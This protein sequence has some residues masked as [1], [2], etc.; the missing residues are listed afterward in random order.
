MSLAEW[1][2]PDGGLDLPGDLTYEAWEE[3]GGV[4]VKMEKGILWAIGDW[5]NYG[6]RRY[7]D[8]AAQAA[9]TGY[10]LSTLR[11]AA[12]V[13]GRFPKSQRDPEIPWSHY[14]EVSSLP[15]AQATELLAVVKDEH[16]SQKDLRTRVRGTQSRNAV[17]LEKKR[18]DVATEQP[19]R[20]P[21]IHA[22]PPWDEASL[23]DLCDMDLPVA[24]A[25]V[26]FLWC[27]VTHLVSGLSVVSAWGFG[28]AANLVWP[29]ALA[30]ESVFVDVQHTHV[31]V[32]SRGTL[33]PI[34]APRSLL[35][36]GEV[37]RRAQDKLRD[38]IEEAYPDMPAYEPW[39]IPRPV[40]RVR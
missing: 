34:K 10:A 30:D 25:A 37:N 2:R 7:G 23:D 1:W 26:L 20:F 14:R 8:R 13:A 21:V 5:M 31:L 39:P 24:A 3:L 12:W 36:L 29:S 35:E 4:L 28:Y 38:V 32:G 33:L 40:V 9:P 6:E 17:A 11:A 19:D 16:L 18:A 27:P 22:D 15:P